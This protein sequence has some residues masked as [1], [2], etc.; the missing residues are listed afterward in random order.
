VA[1]LG[2]EERERMRA[3]SVRSLDRATRVRPLETVELA[4]L[5]ALADYLAQRIERRLGFDSGSLAEPLMLGLMAGYQ[6]AAGE[7]LLDE[8]DPFAE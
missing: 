5:S 8:P 1:G 4:R 6:L 3:N 7:P 2:V